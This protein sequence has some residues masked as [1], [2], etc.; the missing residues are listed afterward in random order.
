M[1]WEGKKKGKFNSYFWPS[2]LHYRVLNNKTV[3]KKKNEKK[4]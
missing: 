4:I 2:K 1:V 3:Y